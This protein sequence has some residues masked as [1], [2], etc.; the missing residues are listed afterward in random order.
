[1]KPHRPEEWDVTVPELA[2][3]LADIKHGKSRQSFICNRFFVT[4]QTASYWLKLVRDYEQERVA[5]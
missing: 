1:M 2:M 5:S 3:I 4:D